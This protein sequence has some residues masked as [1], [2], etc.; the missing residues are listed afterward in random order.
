[1]EKQTDNCTPMQKQTI[2]NSCN[3][4]KRK[5]IINVNKSHNQSQY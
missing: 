2:K 1:M 5:L 3:N 4:F